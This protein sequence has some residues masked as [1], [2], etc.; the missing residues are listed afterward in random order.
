VASGRI[1]PE[2]WH[3]DAEGRVIGFVDLNTIG[4]GGGLEP[5]AE[6]TPST[7]NVGPP[8]L[9]KNKLWF[10][11]RVKFVKDEDLGLDTSTWEREWS[12]D[13]IEGAIRAA[14]R[15]KA[16]VATATPPAPLVAP[17]DA[18][19][20]GVDAGGGGGGLPP[21]DG[22]LPPSD[23]G[24]GV[25]GSGQLSL[26]E[27]MEI[28]AQEPEVL[29]GEALRGQG[30]RAG[31]PFT[32]L[33]RRH[34][35]ER[36]PLFDLG[37]LL[38]QAAGQPNLNFSDFLGGGAG[39]VDIEGLRGLSQGVQAGGPFESVATFLEGNPEAAFGAA[40]GLSPFANAPAAFRRSLSG[41]GADL[42]SQWRSGVS[43][44]EEEDT[45]SADFLRFLMPRLGL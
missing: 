8:H 5:E 41:L 20:I 34:L 18:P 15:K 36:Q 11:E 17:S 26:R 19:S 39:G 23:G 37:Q 2:G 45:A 14:Q 3:L 1:T 4:T 24:V 42:H 6:A 13:G 31:G 30:F 33:M 7:E 35:Q 38:R 44:G 43:L 32:D 27:L 10:E 22:G 25:D 28:Q 29:I 9:L 21:S 40:R 12:S 16:E